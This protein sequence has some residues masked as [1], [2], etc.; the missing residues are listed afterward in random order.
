M[1]KIT[2]EYNKA[3]LDLVKTIFDTSLSLEAELLILAEIAE[4]CCCGYYHNNKISGSNL[5]FE[6]ARR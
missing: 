4:K 6:L 5:N 3:A 1:L 2:D